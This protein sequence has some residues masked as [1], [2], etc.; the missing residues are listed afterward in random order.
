[1][2]G[3]ALPDIL[4]DTA[5]LAEHLNDPKLRIVDCRYYFDG[6]DGAAIYRGGHLP[7]AVYASYP[8]DLADP[9]ATPPNL[10]PQPNQLAATMG[11]LGIGD[12][13]LV[14][15]YDDEGGHFASRLWWV[16][17]Y[18]GH[19]RVKILNGGIQEWAREGQPLES[20]EVNPSPAT[21][22]PGEP[23]EGMRIRGDALRDRL[24]EKGLIVLDVRRLSEYTGDEVRA[25][26]GGRVPGAI[27]A[28]WQDNLN[29]NWTFRSADELRRRHLAVGATPEGAIV[30]Y[31]QGGV[32]AAH[33]YLALLLAG[34]TNVQMY[35]GSWAEWGNRPELP[36]ETGT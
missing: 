33:A 11:R 36:I 20:G 2:T 24:G 35:D 18:F 21:F 15:G 28:F 22:T 16:L 10:I 6:R 14:V 3:Y 12:D 1:M 17:T 19:D 25:A 31:C 9:T 34:Y 27:H 7:G 5:W 30:T 13:T 29:P 8:M 23:R 4:A 32:R 26:R